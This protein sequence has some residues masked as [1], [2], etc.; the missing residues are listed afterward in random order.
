MNSVNRN[1]A[2]AT[3]VVVVALLGGGVYYYSRPTAAPTSVAPATTSDNEQPTQ[4]KVTA[5]FT[6]KNTVSNPSTNGD[7]KVGDVY[8]TLSG[9]VTQELLLKKG[10][11]SLDKNG[12]C[13]NGGLLEVVGSTIGSYNCW[14]AGGGDNFTLIRK[15]DVLMVE[16]QPAAEASPGVPYTPP[17]AISVATFTLPLNALVTVI[18]APTSITTPN[19]PPSNWMTYNNSNLDV[20]FSYPKD[21]GTVYIH[22]QAWPPTI[23]VKKSKFTCVQAISPASAGTVVER[24]LHG[25]DFCIT[26]TSEGAAGSTYTTYSYV[27]PQNYV[28]AQQ[29][30]VFV[31]SVVLRK[32]QC[33]NYND[34]QKSACEKELS[35]FNLDDMIGSITAT[36]NTSTP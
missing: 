14:W 9:A 13:P 22:P 19:T 12:Q 23:S 6:T 1:I 17:A 5:A 8:L 27:S 34:P 26:A 25:R 20:S 4:P 36:L 21:L 3:A 30:E 35:T 11:S 33:A 24:T 28:Y 31:L 10:V 15:G 16:Y 7:N 18:G 32:P 29:D 2:I